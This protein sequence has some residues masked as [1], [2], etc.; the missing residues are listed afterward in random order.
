MNG[1][2]A[3]NQ[4]L[5]ICKK[6]RRKKRNASKYQDFFKKAYLVDVLVKCVRRYV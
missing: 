1:R 2:F 5:L 4:N 3:E 6:S